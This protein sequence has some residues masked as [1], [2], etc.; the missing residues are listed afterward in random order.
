MIYSLY[1]K[2]LNLSESHNISQHFLTRIAGRQ[3]QKQA[4]SRIICCKTYLCVNTQVFI[5]IHSQI[6]GLAEGFHI[7]YQAKT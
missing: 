3:Q 5:V 7:F 4:V 2:L 1:T 6:E